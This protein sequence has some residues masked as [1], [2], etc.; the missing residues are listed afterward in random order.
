MD[1]ERIRGAAEQVVR[2]EGLEIVDEP[3]KADRAS[4]GK[5]PV[6]AQDIGSERGARDAGQMRR[7]LELHGRVCLRVQGS[8]MLPWVRPGDLVLVE[9]AVSEEARCGEV[10][11]AQ[12]EGQL[13]AHRLIEKHGGDFPEI[14]TKGDAHP[15]AD[16]RLPASDLLGRVLWI[17]RGG[18]RLHLD[19]RLR[20]ALALCVALFSRH[21]R[22]WYP[23]ARLA[24]HAVRPVRR[25]FSGPRPAESQ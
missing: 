9:R 2:S 19:S 21:S 20:S 14:V 18:K 15:A 8:S 25:F 12:R 7:N 3:R 1:L 22:L 6:S 10:V 5:L 11:L 16:P 17:Q 23:A 13:F 4:D 24:F